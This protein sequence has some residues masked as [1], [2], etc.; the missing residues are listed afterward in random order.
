MNKWDISKKGKEWHKKFRR[1]YYKWQK[2][3]NI[4]ADKEGQK[5]FWEINKKRIKNQNL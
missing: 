1:E 3:N 2:N 5:I 4:K